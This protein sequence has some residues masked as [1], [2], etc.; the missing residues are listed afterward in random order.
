MATYQL[1]L[2]ENAVGSLDEAL[3][4]IARAESEGPAPLKFAVLHFAQFLELLLKRAI[5]NEHSL[6]IFRVPSSPNV[7]QTNTVAVREAICLI[8]NIGL[9]IEDGFIAAIEELATLRNSIQHHEAVIDSE[10]L[11]PLLC[12]CATGALEFSAATGIHDVISLLSPENR[13]R[14]LMLLQTDGPAHK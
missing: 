14:F 10:R 8:R 13:P 6:L 1:N 4:Q 12:A 7:R 5:A 9:R 2:L 3:R 11:W